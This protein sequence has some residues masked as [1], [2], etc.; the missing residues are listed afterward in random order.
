LRDESGAAEE[1]QM[2]W[3]E[4]IFG[5]S[6]DN[7]DGSAEAA[8]VATLCIIAVVVF[9]A[10]VPKARSYAKRLLSDLRIKPPA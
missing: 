4:R 2:D 1:E 5:I 7:G 10:A 6:P 3:I 8:I 9:F